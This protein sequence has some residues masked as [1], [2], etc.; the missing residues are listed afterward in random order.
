MRAGEVRT[1]APT[2]PRRQKNAIFALKIRVMLKKH[3]KFSAQVFKTQAVFLQGL[4]FL[5]DPRTRGDASKNCTHQVQSTRLL[6]LGRIPARFDAPPRPS[7][8]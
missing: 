1:F 2:T 5:Q 7:H 8:P 6:N 4:I 3:A